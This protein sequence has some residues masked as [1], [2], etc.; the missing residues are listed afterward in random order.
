MTAY[1]GRNLHTDSIDRDKKLAQ[2]LASEFISEADISKKEQE[3]RDEEF[4]RYL[5]QGVQVIDLDNYVSASPVISTSQAVKSEAASPPKSEDGSL[6]SELLTTSVERKRQNA[7][8]P[9]LTAKK[10]S[11]LPSNFTQMS[12][13]SSISAPVAAS[14]LSSPNDLQCE[15]CHWNWSPLTKVF[16]IE[17]LQTC[18]LCLRD[19][20]KLKDVRK[21]P[22]YQIKN[23]CRRCGSTSC[24]ANHSNQQIVLSCN[25]CRRQRYYNSSHLAHKYMPKAVG[26]IGQS[27]SSTNTCVV[28]SLTPNWTGDQRGIY[29]DS[30]VDPIRIAER[31]YENAFDKAEFRG[32]GSYG[33]D[34]VSLKEMLAN[35]RPDEEFHG[36]ADAHV[37]GM[38]PHVTLMKHQIK[39]IAWM[40]KMEEGSNRGGILADDMGLGKTIQALSIMVSVPSVS[41]PDHLPSLIVVPVALLHQW[42]T[43][44]STKTSPRLAVYT[45]HGSKKRFTTYGDIKSFQVVITTYGSIASEYRQYSNWQ[46]EVEEAHAMPI[47]TRPP[48]PAMPEFM[49]LHNKF[50]R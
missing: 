28:D 3:K 26:S 44:I 30:R 10:Q 22:S 47:E 12:S 20:S 7:A 39:G 9:L 13:A 37:Q 40:R 25:S 21:Q 34:R 33:D 42:E 23:R 43:E 18:F 8:A 38:A 4:A 41:G 29:G 17:M 48:P 14:P 1:N 35:I 46:K 15:H 50:H 11:S 19:S 5:A 6:L 36:D 31:F 32:S 24:T 49:F 45:H 27:S 16:P 2:R